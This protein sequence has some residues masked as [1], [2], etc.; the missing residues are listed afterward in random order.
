[1]FGRERSLVQHFGGESFVL[2]GV[3][4]EESPEKLCHIQQR[5]QLGWT[6]WWDG[7]GGPIAAAWGVDR[8]PAFF[9]VDGRGVIR[10]HEFGAPPAGVLER[11]VEELIQEGRKS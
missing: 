4:A 6:S 7:R 9:L 11:K 10:W 2:L 1:M 8:Y 5:A 3:N